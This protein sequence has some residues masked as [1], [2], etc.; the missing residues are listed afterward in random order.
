MLTIGNEEFRN[1]E[2]QVEKNKND[3]LYM[4]EEE[5][6]LNQ[7]GIKVVGQ[8]QT[9]DAL[10]DPATYTGD[11]GDAYAIGTTSPYILYIYTRANGTHPNNYWFNIGQFPM[12][13]PK[14]EDGKDGAPG[15]QG[16]QGIQGIQGPRGVQ[17]AQGIQGPIGPQGPQGLQGIQGPKGDPGQSFQIVGILNSTSMLPTPT[18]EIRSQAY[19]VP[20]A[21]EAG[22]YDLYVITGTDTLVWENAGHVESVQGP[23]GDVGPQGPQGPQG[24]IGPQGPQGVNGIDG[25]EFLF[26]YGSD[27]F[28]PLEPSF[29]RSVTLSNF[30]RT[31]VVGDYG[32]MII[33]NPNGDSYIQVFNVT[34]IGETT[35]NITGVMYSRLTRRYYAC[36]T[37][38]PR[39][40]E[41]GNLISKTK[42]PESNPLYEVKQ[43]DLMVALDTA[44]SDG[45][46]YLVLGDIRGITK[47]TTGKLSVNAEIQAVTKINGTDGKDGAGLE[48][49]TSLNMSEGQETVTYDTTNGINVSTSGKITY[50]SPA[51]EQSFTSE[52]QLPIVAGDGITI[53]PN[54]AGDKVE[55]SSTA[56]PSAS[57]PIDIPDQ[58]EETVVLKQENPDYG[59][60]NILSVK[61]L[62]GYL[63]IDKKFRLMHYNYPY[64]INNYNDGTILSE[65]APL[66][67]I[68]AHFNG[69]G[70]DFD[71]IKCPVLRYDKGTKLY[72]YKYIYFDSNGSPVDVFFQTNGS[73]TPQNNATIVPYSNPTPVSTSFTLTKFKLYTLA[74]Q[75]L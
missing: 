28:A 35:C 2:E 58:S 52:Y 31:P 60:I 19:L 47:L 18:E 73:G 56:S 33:D 27:V 71:I 21:T 36:N 6:V 62:W 7:F 29:Q 32:T 49:I 67:F 22:T 9:V 10:P 55:I 5:G 17:G 12:P 54:T 74:D 1:L 11:F 8:G 57:L 20:D 68:D 24:P 4:L 44:D 39:V 43:D 48:T 41:V 40:P 23:K 38:T 14:G 16:P 72:C 65:Y 3:I 50:G 13:G 30:N 51:Q 42:D 25:A 75:Y 59:T 45:N 15:L 70:Y 53:A 26:Y 66:Q 63:K 46:V 37:T 34:Y 69:G 61:S 64:L